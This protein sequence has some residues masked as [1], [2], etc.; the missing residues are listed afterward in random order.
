MTDLRVETGK[1]RGPGDSAPP[2]A[3]PRKPARPGVILEDIEA[4]RL[5][6]RGRKYALRDLLAKPG[7]DDPRV[8]RRLSSFAKP[9]SGSLV[10]AFLLSAIAATA[11]LGQVFVMKHMLA[12][13][14]HGARSL[15]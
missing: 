8:Y 11:T 6:Q 2:P 15:T 4:R 9:Y 3:P 13:I 12:P 5:R 10:L 1:A 14:L 7:P